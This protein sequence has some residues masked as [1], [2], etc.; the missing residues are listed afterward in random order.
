M[1]FCC[2]ST[3]QTQ[4]RHATPLALL[5][6]A[7]GMRR[8]ALLTP[9]R[10]G[11]EMARPAD[12]VRRLVG[13]HG[14]LRLAACPP[15]PF[16]HSSPPV[17]IY[18]TRY[19]LFSHQPI[20]AF[21]PSRPSCWSQSLFTITKP[22]SS[23]RTQL[24]DFTNPFLTLS[25]HLYYPSSPSQTNLNMR[26]STAMVLSTFAIGQAAAAHNR[27]ASFHARRQG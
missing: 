13:E 6:L 18:H 15:F 25:P 20:R 11:D 19:P 26:Y 27:H 14:P 3:A 1:S 23:P 17:Q 7:T 5:R 21:T 22:A 12:C 24:N 10:P 8:R 16:S 2:R 9:C 4:P